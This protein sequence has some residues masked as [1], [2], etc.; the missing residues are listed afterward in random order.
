MLSLFPESPVSVWHQLID[1]SVQVQ[2]R[3]VP[4]VDT[5][6]GSMTMSIRSRYLDQQKKDDGNKQTN[7]IHLHWLG[8]SRICLNILAPDKKM[9]RVSSDG[10]PTM[11]SLNHLQ[12]SNHAKNLYQR[13]AL[14]TLI[15]ITYY[16]ST[17]PYLSLGCWCLRKIL[18]FKLN[19]GTVTEV[20]WYDER[21]SCFACLPETLNETPGY[22]KFQSSANWM[23][24]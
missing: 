8:S 17:K 23:L 21:Y 20:L 16:E 10:K 6:P 11:E 24:L 13:L 19:T 2:E 22:L 3:S 7:R 1:V 18:S 4:S 15:K 14:A 12:Y 9:I 5:T